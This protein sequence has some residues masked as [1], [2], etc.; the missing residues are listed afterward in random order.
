MNILFNPL[1][2]V[3]SAILFDYSAANAQKA[4]G[5]FR[6]TIAAVGSPSN[7]DIRYDGSQMEALQDLGFN[8]LQLNVVWG[9]RPKDEPLN[10][11]LIS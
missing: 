10:R 7:P 5:K 3:L 4:A 6:Y 2:Y 9:T 1:H 11:C 8:T